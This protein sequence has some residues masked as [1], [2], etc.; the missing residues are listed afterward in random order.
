M[1]ANYKF[2]IRKNN[3]II[4]ILAIN[5]INLECYETFLSNTCVQKITENAGHIITFNNFSCY[6]NSEKI[7]VLGKV[8]DSLMVSFNVQYDSDKYATYIF[9]LRHVYEKCIKHLEKI[10]LSLLKEKE[11]ENEMEIFKAE[12]LK[13]LSKK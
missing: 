1:N 10:I 7:N 3:E 12:M 13:T 4:E 8:D 9:A 6:L 5:T 2:N 11:N